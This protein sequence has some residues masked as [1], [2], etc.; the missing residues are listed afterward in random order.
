M[1][2]N[3]LIT[4]AT[5]LVGSH[6]QQQ[7]ITNHHYQKIY[8]IQRR[9]TDTSHVKVEEIVANLEDLSAVDLPDI[10]AAFC[11][12]GTTMKQA[13]SKEKFKKVDFEMVI[14]T[15]RKAKESGASVFCVISAMGANSGSSIFY[16]QVK[17]EMEEALEEFDFD[18][19]HIFRPSILV[20]DRQEFRLGEN[21]GIFFAKLLDPLMK[22]PLQKYR[23]S[24]AQKVA[25][26]MEEKSLIPE[27][28]LFVWEAENFTLR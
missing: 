4:G 8:S 22:G 20:G 2:K 3:A 12:L 15:A 14:N 28:G 6:L 17:G 5:G 26:L 7:L 19:L 24:S 16:N 27:N 25:H 11:C 9:K 10:H 21:L 1:A 13:G 23:A 18:A